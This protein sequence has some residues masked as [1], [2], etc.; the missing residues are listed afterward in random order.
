MNQLASLAIFFSFLNLVIALPVLFT[1]EYFRKRIL[2]LLGKPVNLQLLAFPHF[3]IGYLMVSAYPW[4]NSTAASWISVFGY[5]VLLRSVLW[6]WFPKAIAAK[7]KSIVKSE[8]GMTIIGLV[9]LAI[10]V[11]FAYLGYKVY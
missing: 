7:V 1:Q 10:A 8:N 6:F 2:R 11:L 5:L 3:V 9:S 4:I